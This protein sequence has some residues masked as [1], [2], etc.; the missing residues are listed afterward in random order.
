MSHLSAATLA[1]LR[2]SYDWLMSDTCTLILRGESTADDYGLPTVVWT[3]GAG[4]ACGLDLGGGSGAKHS[5]QVQPGTF[6]PVYDARLRLPIGTDVLNLD[7]VR[8]T[9]RHGEA[10][11]TG[12][13][14][15]VI[16][17]PMRGPLG[18]VLLLKT[19]TEGEEAGS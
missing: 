9:H 15:S 18:L 19:V 3:E 14:F 5:R 6:V 7:R 10:L 2:K 4:I 8:V 13:L 16:G 12:L 17:E 1:S 11:A